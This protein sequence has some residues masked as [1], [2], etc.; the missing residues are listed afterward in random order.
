M[1]ATRAL[2]TVASLIV[3]VAGLNAAQPILIPVL[4][5]LLLAILCS[6]AVFWLR[7]HRVPTVAAVLLVVLILLG[8]LSVFGVVVG[9]SI[10]GFMEAAPRYQ[11]RIDTLG[12]S[13]TGWMKA[14]GLDVGEIDTSDVFQPGALIGFLGR[15]LTAVLS[16]VSNTLVVTLI[17]VFMLLEAAGLPIKLR[18]AL[19]SPDADLRR[20]TKAAREIQ[21]YL[22]L[23]TAISALTGLL[24]GTWVAVLGLDFALT[25]GFLAFLLNFIPNIGSIIA[26]VPAVLLALVQLG[27]AQALLVAA[28]FVVVNVVL[29]NLVE[30]QLMGRTLGMSTLVIFLS[31]VFWGWLWGPVGMFLSVPLTMILKIGMENSRDLKPIAIM[32]DSTRAATERLK[33]EARDDDRPAGA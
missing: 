8:V 14:Q 33:N 13:L 24:I 5:A 20:F 19:G 6:P 16:M 21:K 22:G 26:A 23:K 7:E 29:G 25:W 1:P 15:G 30:P 12:S 11:Q 28:G 2:L 17:L 31:L 10:N 32:L 9:G 27:L 4:L 3:V 18:A